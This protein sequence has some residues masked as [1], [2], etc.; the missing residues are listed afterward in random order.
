[1]LYEAGLGWD[2]EEFRKLFRGLQKA[3]RKMVRSA[4]GFKN[5][6]NAETLPIGP[7]KIN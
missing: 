2:K 6:V 3:T 5:L 7:L 1:M 4:G